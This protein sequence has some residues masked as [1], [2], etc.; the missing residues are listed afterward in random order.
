MNKYAVI[1]AG[2]SGTRMKS[3][4]P[5]Q[6]LELDGEP[7]LMH[8]L[9]AFYA[10]D[11]QMKIILC[12]PALEIQ[13][14]EDLCQ[15]HEFSIP[16][17]IV[18]GGE[19]RYHSVR[20]GLEAIEGSEDYSFVAIH[21]GVR[22]LISNWLLEESFEQAGKYGCAI[23]AVPIKDS[24][25]QVDPHGKNHMVDRSIFRAVQTPQTFSILEIKS[26][27]EMGYDKS[28][29]DDASVFEA[30]GKEI[31]L[32]EGDYHNIKITTP[33]DLILAKAFLKN[34]GER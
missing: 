15:K 16:H 22:P 21:D 10:F 24:L 5:K 29:T 34:K 33:E 30:Y 14:W 32:F 17:Q 4:L 2:G 3:H 6:F 7:I 25:R 1:V 9:K 18:Q 23:P 13:L 19:T 28:F 26:A 27:F 8:T 11:D 31:H 12:L 20:N